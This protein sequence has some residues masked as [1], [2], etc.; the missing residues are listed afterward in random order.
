MVEQE[1]LLEGDVKGEIIA[2]DFGLGK[3]VMI[4][5]ILLRQ[6][7]QLLEKEAC[8]SLIVCPNLI[9]ERWKNEIA[10]FSSK[11]SSPKVHVYHGSGNSIDIKKLKSCDIV[12][13]G[14]GTVQTE[15]DRGGELF[16]IRWH[17]I[18]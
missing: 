1:M 4:I 5:A 8:Q 12:I 7:P 18:V 14:T 10:H 15:K 2:D 3:T 11:R 13:A 9:M 16:L 6:G 17:R